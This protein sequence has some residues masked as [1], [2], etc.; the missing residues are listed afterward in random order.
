MPKKQVYECTCDRCSRTWYPEPIDGKEPPVS[1]LTFAFFDASPVTTESKNG[2]V[3]RTFEVLCSTCSKA[4]R[5]YLSHILKEKGAAEEEGSGA[6]E[7]GDGPAP[8]PPPPIRR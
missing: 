7:E 4:V 2:P 3:E 8:A 1:S 5:N 6:S